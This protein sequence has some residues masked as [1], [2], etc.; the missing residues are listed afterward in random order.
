MSETKIKLKR[1]A[2]PGRVPTTEQ[3]DFGE[4]ALNTH[5]GVLYTK[6]EED[7]QVSIRDLSIGTHAK[8][9][10]HEFSAAAGQDT[11]V[12]PGGYNRIN[13]NIVFQNGVMLA[14][15]Q[16]TATDGANVILSTPAEETDTIVVI[17]PVNIIPAITEIDDNI[18]SIERT[19][20]SDKINSEILNALDG[21]LF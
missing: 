19:W 8:I 3:I 17:K 21:G 20:S 18:I 6:V 9:E 5:D 15:S 12:I 10:T 14:P 7:G 1:S 13:V 2:I 4:L 16:F 11:F